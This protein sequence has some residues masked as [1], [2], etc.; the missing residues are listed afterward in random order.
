MQQHSRVIVHQHEEVR[1][2]AAADTRMR[3]ERTDQHVADPQLIWPR[4]LEPAEGA[5]LASQRGAL[6][7]TLTQMLA[8]G[9]FGDPNAMPRKENG[10]DLG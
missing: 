2:A 9:A 1:A 5:G 3:N 6:E 4:R 7:P 8:D 10:G